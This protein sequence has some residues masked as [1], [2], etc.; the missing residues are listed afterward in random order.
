[1]QGGVTLSFE[2]GTYVDL[3]ASEAM[4][5]SLG[6]REVDYVVGHYAKCGEFT[7]HVKVGAYD[8][9]PLGL[10]SDVGAVAFTAEALRTVEVD[11]NDSLN[12]EGG[13]Q[14]FRHLIR[15]TVPYA[16]VVWRHEFESDRGWYSTAG[17][18]FARDLKEERTTRE[19]TLGIGRTF[20]TVTVELVA[21]GYTFTNGHHD[22][23]DVVSLGIVKT[24]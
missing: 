12:F 21:E 17:F 14:Y 9:P 20:G 2:N 22:S 18:G 15:T 11:G 7:C 1:V 8:L 16:R 23:H 5:H 13:V 3:W 10:S 24:F 19:Y 4:D 6:G